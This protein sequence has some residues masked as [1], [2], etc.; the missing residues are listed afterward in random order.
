MKRTGADHNHTLLFRLVTSYSSLLLFV[1]ISGFFFMFSLRSTY[2]Q[3]TTLFENG[4]KD[5][6]NS[7]RLFSTLTA[8]FASKEM[9]YFQRTAL[10][11][12]LEKKRNAL[13]AS[14][15]EYL[16]QNFHDPDLSLKRFPK[17]FPSLKVTFPICSRQK[18]E[19]IFQNIW[20]NSG[21]SRQCICS[22]KQTHHFP[23]CM[24]L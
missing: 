8:R 18:P 19:E 16:N 9:F 17:F 13:I 14:I 1:L 22:A 7:L 3:N 6:D 21:C 20:K 12:E 11:D 2:R 10:D 23:S 5:M 4:V 15:K 24:L